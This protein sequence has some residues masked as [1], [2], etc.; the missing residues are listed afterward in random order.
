MLCKLA[1]HSLERLL[2]Y[3]SITVL[4]RLVLCDQGGTVSLFLSRLTYHIWYMAGKHSI[5]FISAYTPKHLNVEAN[6][7]S[8]GIPVVEWN[9]LHAA[10]AAFQLEVQLD[11]D[12]SILIYQLMSKLLHASLPWGGLGLNS[13][14]YPWCFSF[15]CFISSSFFFKFPAEHVMSQSRCLIILMPYWMEAHLFSAVNRHMGGHSLL[16]HHIKGSHQDNLIILL[17]FLVSGGKIN[18]VSCL[19]S[20]IYNKSLSNVQC[21]PAIYY[22]GL[23][24][25]NWAL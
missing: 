5:I 23:F 18:Q 20:K 3:I 6:Y 14:N 12:L 21:C 2:Q 4:Q 16:V 15:S 9:L 19:P 1:F 13:F 25:T 7:L 17:F 24:Q 8:L 10:Q 22:R 11:V